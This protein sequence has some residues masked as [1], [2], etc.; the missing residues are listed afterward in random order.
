MADPVH[1]EDVR[2]RAD[3]IHD[4]EAVS[5]AIARM[6]R[7]ISA[8]LAERDPL[9]LAVL[10][11]GLVPTARLLAHLRF[12]YQL[13][14]LQATRYH[15]GTAAGALRWHVKPR[16]SVRERTVLVIDDILDEGETLRAIQDHLEAE[17]AAQ[18]YTAVL[19]VKDHSRRRDDVQLDFHGVVVP[20]RY[21]FGCGMD[22]MEYHRGL[23]EILA[24]PRDE[25]GEEAH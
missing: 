12:P 4:A 1:A 15:G 7:E 20:D 22:Y 2:I 23:P 8:V 10:L 11:G 6:G 21:V 25:S 18:V 19:S 3:V 13:D 17:G 16:A 9:I 14:Y 24:L 5:D